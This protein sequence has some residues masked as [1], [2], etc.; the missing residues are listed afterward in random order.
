MEKKFNSPLGFNLKIMLGKYSATKR[1]IRNKITNSRIYD[2]K[3]G[4]WIE[5]KGC[6]NWIKPMP[7]VTKE[8]TFPISMQAVN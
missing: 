7:K 8:S 6:R 2:P 5:T 1:V 3:A 4:K